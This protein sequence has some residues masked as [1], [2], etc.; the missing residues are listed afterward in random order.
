MSNF[1]LYSS[2]LLTYLSIG[3]AIGIVETAMPAYMRS[4][5]CRNYPIWNLILQIF[6][7]PLFYI[8]INN[9]NVVQKIIKLSIVSVFGLFFSNW[10]ANFFEAYIGWD[11][12]FIC[13]FLLMSFINLF[14][15]GMLNMP[16]LRPHNS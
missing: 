4:E 15:F 16:D 11:F 3:G 12:S 6:I 5:L 10:I 14:L 7:W 2:C 8:L 13:T 1:H 9:H